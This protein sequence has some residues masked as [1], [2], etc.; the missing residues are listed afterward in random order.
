M[1]LTELWTRQDSP[2][3]LTK[4]PVRQDSFVTWWCLTAGASFE[5]SHCCGASY[6]GSKVK[7]WKNGNHNFITYLQ[8]SST[9]ASSFRERFVVSWGEP[10]RNTSILMLSWCLVA[11][12]ASPGMKFVTDFSY[13]R[14][15]NIMLLPHTK[16]ITWFNTNLGI[17][18]SLPTP[19]SHPSPPPPPT[20]RQNTHGALRQNLTW[21][22]FSQT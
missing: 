8:A 4:L 9:T 1:L 18:H 10:Q 13:P 2:A 5:G 21:K 6:L 15:K 16:Q 17:S 12:T 22:T 3:F 14:E 7:K 20:S 19:R 11:W